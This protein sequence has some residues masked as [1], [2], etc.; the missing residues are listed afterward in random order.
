MSWLLLLP[1][2]MLNAG[3]AL[4]PTVSTL[5]NPGWAASVVVLA[6]EP[7]EP[8]RWFSSCWSGAGRLVNGLRI[9]IV[10]EVV[11]GM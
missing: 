11:N 1:L 4:D 2:R 6:F 9:G 5:S 8:G 7:A 10:R 3:E